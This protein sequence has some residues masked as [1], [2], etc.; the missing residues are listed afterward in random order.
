MSVTKLPTRKITWYNKVFINKLNV[1]KSFWVNFLG[2]M[3][4]GISIE[5]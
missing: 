1:N 5:E 2:V 4:L 3:V